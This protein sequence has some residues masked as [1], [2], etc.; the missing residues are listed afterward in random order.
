MLSILNL[1][2]RKAYFFD[3]RVH[4]TKISLNKK[5]LNSKTVKEKLLLPNTK[6]CN[7]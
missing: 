3:R 7:F 5:N 2:L 1:F 4:Y 6:T